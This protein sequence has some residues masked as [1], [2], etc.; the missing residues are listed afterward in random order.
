[1]VL[2]SRVAPQEGV[3][4][5]ARDA[6]QLATNERKNFNRG[7]VGNQQ[8]KLARAS[9][10]RILLAHVSSGPRAPFNY[11][12]GLQIPQRAPDGG[13]GNA[14]LLDQL[15]LAREPGGRAIFSGG[16]LA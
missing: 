5:R 7:Q 3:F 15:L 12:V 9:G 14:E 4:L 8:A 13:A 16:D 11:A 1:M 2:L 6:G 10:I